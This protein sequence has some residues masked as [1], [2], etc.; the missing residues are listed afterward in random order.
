MSTEIAA[1]REK[2]AKA[3]QGL[4]GC[5]RMAE[6]GDKIP[7]NSVT[8]MVRRFD[9]ILPLLADA[10]AGLDHLMSSGQEPLPS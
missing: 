9:N 2:V 3:R 7:G 6:L 5:R 4:A 1:I 8:D 10:E